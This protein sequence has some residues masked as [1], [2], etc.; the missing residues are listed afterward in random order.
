M[1]INSD[2]RCKPVAV[3]LL[4]NDCGSGFAKRRDWE[5]WSH[6]SVRAG[7][8]DCGAMQQPIPIS[9]VR[10]SALRGAPN[11]EL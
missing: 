2:L 9:L 4:R 11:P 5:L 10:N 3:G 7:N 1:S 8:S 6:R